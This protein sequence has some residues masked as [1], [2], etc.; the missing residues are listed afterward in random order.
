MKAANNNFHLQLL[1]L[2]TAINDNHYSHPP[3]SM[4]TLYSIQTQGMANIF[5]LVVLPR[6]LPN[7]GPS[8]REEF[9]E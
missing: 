6:S 4:L 9:L 1:V 2:S 5:P 3:G 7:S 8:H